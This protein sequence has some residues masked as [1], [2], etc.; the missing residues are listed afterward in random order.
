LARN[1]R[2]R[3]P[4]EFAAVRDARREVSLR[5]SGPW[6]S[7]TAAWTAAAEARPVRLGVTVGKRLARRSI[8][9]AL[10]KRIVREA[11]RHASPA[12]DRAALRAGAAIDVSLRLRSPL[13]DPGAPGRPAQM[14]LRR[15]L[16]ADADE[17]LAVLAT[18]L[19]ALEAH[20]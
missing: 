11:F 4:R 10:V 16:R 18:R 6:L 20:A 8:D 17:L 9:R 15:A 5:A 1:Q 14:P 3:R 13:V 12:L 19:S 7:M 2:L